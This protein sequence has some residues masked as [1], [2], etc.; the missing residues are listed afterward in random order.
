MPSINEVPALPFEYALSRPPTVVGSE[1]TLLT[2][3]CGL[4]PSLTALSSASAV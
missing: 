3:N 2:T 1:P 4:K